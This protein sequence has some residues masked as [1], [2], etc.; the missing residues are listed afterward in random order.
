MPA[1]NRPALCIAS[2]FLVAG[3]AVPAWPAAAA[4][5][6]G[7]GAGSP[8][9]RPADHARYLP[10][11]VFVKLRQ[12]G[13]LS[14]AKSTG[15]PAVDAV[16]SRHA[17][18]ALLPVSPRAR[19]PRKPGAIDLSRVYR[20]QYADGTDALRVARELAALPEVEYAEPRFVYPLLL[21]PNDPS[22]A[23]KQ[24]IYYNKMQLPTAFN[25]TIGSMGDVVVAICDGGT[26]W[27]HPDLAA[28]VWV[29]PGETAANGLDDDANGYVDDV[30]G[31][32]FANGT[33][34]PT[35]LPGTPESAGHGTHVAGIACAVTNNS[36][37]V[38]G[39]SYNATY[40]PIC[41]ADPTTDRAIA[42]G[43]D[44]II[45]AADNG[46]DIVNCSWGGLGSA[47]AFEA[48]VVA[49]A[50]E[51]GTV[52]VAAAGNDNSVQPSYPASYE[53]VFSVANVTSADVRSSSS[54]YGLTVDVS[55]PG[56]LIYSTY[57]TNTYTSLSGTS[58]ASPHAAAVCALVKT[59]WPGYL[60]EQVMQ[61]VRVTC[62]N[63]DASN[64]SYVGLLGYGRLNAWKALTKNTPAVTPV[65][66]SVTTSDGDGVIEPGETLTIQVDV[67]NWLASCTGLSFK[68]RENTTYTTMVDSAATLAVLD[69]LE[70]ATLPAFT[71]SISP[72]APVQTT[73]MFTLVTTT[74]TPAYTDKARFNLTILPTYMIH[75]ANE[76]Q[77]TVTSVGK[78]GY[79][80]VAGGTGSDGIGFHYRNSAGYLFE[81]GLMIGLSS[82]QVSDACRTSA[83][84]Q[85]DDFLTKPGGIPVV[86][87]PDGPYAEHGVAAFTDSTA[88]N[89]LWL[90][91]RQ[92]SYEVTDPAY[93]DFIVLRYR[94]RND[95]GTA[96]AGLRVGW[97]CDWDIDGGTYDTNF[98]NYDAA[99]GMMYAYDSST[100]GPDDYVGLLTLTSPGTTAARGITNDETIA[101]D[102]GVYDGYTDQEKWETISGGVVHP[103]AGPT[104]ISFGLGTGPF[105]VAAG[106]SIVVAFAFVGGADLT[107]LQAHADAAITWWAGITSDT[108]PPAGAAPR[109]LT[110]AQNTPNPFNPRTAIA[111]ELPREAAVTLR[112]YDV[113]GRC[114]RTLLDAVQPAGPQRVTWDGRDDRGIA[115]ASGTYFYRLTVDGQTLVRKMQILK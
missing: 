29:N 19:A 89:R 30:H 8:A 58:M 32:N 100:A 104:D 38:A 20:L 37:G 26:Q 67:R 6:S 25:T 42:F 61:R 27:Q 54:N 2:M 60:P 71:V 51:Q 83:S 55:A 66:Q 21:V 78:L 106:D 65:A 113:G 91:V 1:G 80:L 5:G 23:A 28:N 39:A 101:P 16:L 72:S 112:V 50:Y 73:V 18:T 93:D 17:A 44:G 7:A 111:Y 53:H 34:D 41:T 102:W 88:D 86:T 115:R 24:Q 114:V 103:L 12:P 105:D 68:L 62:D 98:T 3:L 10:G 22:Y 36:V 76:I 43:Y 108:G 96:Y 81:G 70:T 11:E 92:D 35:G 45:Y 4:G 79:A 63:I 82:T 14:S 85:D 75:D 31:W 97:F 48:E 109:R 69:S 49:Y 94:V 95:R 33:G 107:E 64:A 52:V 13:A 99:R 46:A 77:C 84:T 56:N 74:T 40:M 15:S 59:R 47:S 87:E 57:P 90:D 9:L 110:L